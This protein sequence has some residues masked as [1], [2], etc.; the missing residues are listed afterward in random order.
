MYRC[1]FT[2]YSKLE[3]PEMQRVRS[4]LRETTTF[5]WREPNCRHSRALY[6]VCVCVC[7]CVCSLF[8]TAGVS[9]YGRPPS[10]DIRRHMLFKKKTTSLRFSVFCCLSDAHSSWGWKHTRDIKEKKS[11][12][13]PSRSFRDKRD[14]HQLGHQS[15]MWDVVVRIS[16]QSVGHIALDRLMLQEH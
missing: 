12:C 3:S 15:D 8:T 6:K 2:K 13:V 10:G 9:L 11:V 14:K 16:C 5:S 4:Y 1:F 7:V